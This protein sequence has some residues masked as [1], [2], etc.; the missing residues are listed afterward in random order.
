MSASRFFYVFLKDGKN[1]PSSQEFSINS[2]GLEGSVVSVN[3][4]LTYIAVLQKS[5]EKQ[6][7]QTFTKLQIP[8]RLRQT[9]SSKGRQYCVHLKIT[10]NIY[11]HDCRTL[12]YK[13]QNFRKQSGYFHLD[14]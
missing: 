9:I 2:T 13:M 14:Y 3:R 1:K 12:P 4:I 7:N 10:Y 8:K 6:R 11:I 5:I